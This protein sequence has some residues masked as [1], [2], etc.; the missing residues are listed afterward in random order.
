MKFAKLEGTGN[1]FI[2]I[3]P[4]EEGDWRVLAREMCRYHFGIGADGMILVLQSG[5]PAVQRLAK[6]DFRMRIFNAD[7]SEAEMCGN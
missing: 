3:D 6:A 7:G 4:R 2:I 5:S 1:D